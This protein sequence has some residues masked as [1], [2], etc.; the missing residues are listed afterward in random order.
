MAGLVMGV[1]VT[2][3]GETSARSS[4]VAPAR[5]LTL[6]MHRRAG[7][8]HPED[9]YGF[10]LAKDGKAPDPQEA[11]V[12]GPVLVLKRNEPVE[13]TLVNALPEATAIHWHGIE[14]ES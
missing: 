6:A 7:Y 1:R 4:T 5:K 12:P 10:A 13:I 2:G 3:D 11:N 14:L 8:W 9:A